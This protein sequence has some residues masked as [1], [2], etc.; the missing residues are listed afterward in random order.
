[1]FLKDYPFAYYVHY[2]AYRLQLALVAA[3]REV[4]LVHQ[5]FSSLTSIINIIVGS[6]KWND[7]IQL[8]QAIETS[9]KIDKDEKK[10]QTKLVPY[11][12]LVMLDRVLIFNQFIAC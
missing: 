9:N 6:C 12:D 4:K 2:L 11:N 5:F 8:A 1:L 10:K 7:E 3:S